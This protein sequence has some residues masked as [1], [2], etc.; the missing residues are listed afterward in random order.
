MS[1]G[2]GLIGMLALLLAGLWHAPNACAQVIDFGFKNRA[3][4]VATGDERTSQTN[5]WVLEVQYKS[6]RQL[7]VELLDPK[8]GETRKELI[9]YLIYRVINRGLGEAKDE[10]D[11]DPMNSFDPEV[12]APQF[13]PE[14]TLV[15]TDN[16]RQQ[17]YDD[18][19]VPAAQKVILARE[20]G[21]LRNLGR[22]KNTVD[23][24]GAI[25]PVT[26]AEATSQPALYGIAMWR[27]V[28]PAADYFTIVMSGFSNGYKLVRGP[29]GYQTLLDQVASGKLTF[30][31]QIWDGKTTWKAASETY[32]LFDAKKPAPADPNANIWFY[33]TTY[34]RVSAEDEQPVVWRKTLIQRYWR[35][36]DEINTQEKEFREKGEPEWI[37]QP[38]ELRVP[39]VLQPAS[40]SPAKKPAAAKAPAAQEPK[41]DKAPK[42]DEAAGQDKPGAEDD[43]KK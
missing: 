16:D 3:P 28:D 23:I 43:T 26:P 7:P 13:V 29:V 42:A 38:D 19:I 5:L 39:I 1:R 10:A 12:V 6:L 33:T 11:T 22:L 20:Q 25:P 32:N 9:I 34:D 31:D 36:G 41:A 14:F 35:P 40:V 4:A 15:T 21:R 8:T 37:Y 17:I 27:G 18:V 24:V 30:S 2:L